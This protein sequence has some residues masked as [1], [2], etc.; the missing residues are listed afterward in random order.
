MFGLCFHMHCSAPA[1]AIECALCLG[2]GMFRRGSRSKCLPLVWPCTH[3]HY[4]AGGIIEC[5]CVSSVLV[6][7]QECFFM[8]AGASGCH[9]FGRASLSVGVRCAYVLAGMYCH[10]SRSKS[11]PHVWP[12]THMHCSA[13]SIIEY[14]CSLRLCDCRNVPPWQQEQ[15]LATC[16]AVHPHALFSW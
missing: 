15:V 10:G 7:L 14:G 12:C 9:M 4:S 13:G 6:Y 11:L 16:L 5:G 1:S 2:A 3:L 8:T